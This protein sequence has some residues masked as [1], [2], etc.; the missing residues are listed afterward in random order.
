MGSFFLVPQSLKLP[1]GFTDTVYYRKK[2]PRLASCGLL[3]RSLVGVSPREYVIAIGSHDYAVPDSLNSQDP[4]LADVERDADQDPLHKDPEE[5]QAA[6]TVPQLLTSKEFTKPLIIVCFAMLAQQLSG[7]N[8]GMTMSQVLR[9]MLIV[10]PVLYYSNDILAK[11]L[12]DLGPY[13]SLG[14]TIVNVFMTFPP[15]FLIEV[16]IF[17]S[18]RVELADRPRVISV[19]DAGSS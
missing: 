2:L 4:L 17:S 10:W 11:A 13:V 6:V 16:R 7:V 19:W 18:I 15:I 9:F 8:A 1:A 14:I 5:H 3:V 12:P